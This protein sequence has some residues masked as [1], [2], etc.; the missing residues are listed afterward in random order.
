MHSYATSS[1]KKGSSPLTFIL[2]GQNG[3]LSAG[4]RHVVLLYPLRARAS[5]CTQAEEHTCQLPQCGLHS[6]SASTRAKSTR[7]NKGSI[8]GVLTSM[9][10][11]S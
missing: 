7:K 10:I 9:L 4:G 5:V 1:T 6:C 2:M 11:S 8:H 3:S